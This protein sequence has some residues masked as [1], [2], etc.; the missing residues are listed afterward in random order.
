MT[1]YIVH[2]EALRYRITYRNQTVACVTS[3]AEVVAFTGGN[4]HIWR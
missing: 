1:L 3:W 2:H 4:H